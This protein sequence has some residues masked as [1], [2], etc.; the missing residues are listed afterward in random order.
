ME[1]DNNR[2]AVSQSFLVPLRA[3]PRGLVPL[4]GRERV[5]KRH[6]DR[7]EVACVVEHGFG[8]AEVHEQWKP[9]CSGC[10]VGLASQDPTST[11]KTIRTTCRTWEVRVYD[12]AQD[13]GEEVEEGGRCGVDSDQKQ[14]SSLH[15]CVRPTDFLSA[16]TNFA[17]S[18]FLWSR[19]AVLTAWTSGHAEEERRSTLK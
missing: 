9:H 3:S 15:S 18:L 19:A 12:V 7:V 8:S 4:A 14:R 10:V 5:P 13:P 6:K 2:A 17:R 11:L 16:A 1:I